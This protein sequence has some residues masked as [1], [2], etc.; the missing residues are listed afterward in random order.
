MGKNPFHIH[1]IGTARVLG[2]YIFHLFATQESEEKILKFEMTFLVRPV[3]ML[4]GLRVSEFARSVQFSKMKSV[5]QL[6][7]GS[8]AEGSGPHLCNGRF[9]L[10][11]HQ[12]AQWR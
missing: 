12:A 4:V 3:L 11:W 7:G 2:C 6:S 9:R 1:Q 10:A 5:V 8:E